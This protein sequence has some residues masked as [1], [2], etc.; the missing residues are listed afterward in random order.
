MLL[1]TDLHIAEISTRMSRSQFVKNTLGVVISQMKTGTES[2]MSIS[3]PAAAISTTSFDDDEDGTPEA[4]GPVAPSSPSMKPHPLR[5]HPKNRSGSL[6]SWR[7]IMQNAAGS[8]SAIQ[9]GDGPGSTESPEASRVSLNL[10]PGGG[11]YFDSPERRTSKE[12]IVGSGMKKLY[13]SEVE[14][15]LKVSGIP[16][17]VSSPGRLYLCF[18]KEMYDAVKKQQILQPLGHGPPTPLH[19]KGSQRGHHASSDRLNNLKRGSVRGLQ[20]L[21]GS[22]N[23]SY[24]SGS[25]GGSGDGRVSPSPSVANSI[26][27]VCR[28]GLS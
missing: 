20:S 10:P 11:T 6:G 22:Q 1:N 12:A 16:R 17:L 19:R 24:G 9:L 2:P 27:E 18:T 23:P 21:L 25:S 8:Q 28:L 14:N 13:E 5:H 4:T 7:S 15:L 26:G 3:M